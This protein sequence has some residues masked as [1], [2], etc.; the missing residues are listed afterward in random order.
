MDKLMAMIEATASLEV[1]NL[2]LIYQKLMQ[3]FLSKGSVWDFHEM[4]RQEYLSKSNKEIV[5]II[6]FYK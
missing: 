3:K 1:T 4:G 2:E 5:L 6:K